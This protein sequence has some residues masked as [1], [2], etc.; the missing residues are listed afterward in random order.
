MKVRN[1]FL[2]SLLFKLGYKYQIFLCDPTDLN[3]I[4]KNTLNISFVHDEHGKLQKKLIFNGSAIKG[5]R[6]MK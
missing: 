2:T 1:Y 6:A 5:Y 4:K 3:I